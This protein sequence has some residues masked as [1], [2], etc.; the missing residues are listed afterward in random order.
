MIELGKLGRDK[1]TGFE[2]I[3]TCHAKYLYGC[4]RYCLTPTSRD[5]DGKMLDG[6]FLDEGRIE[7]LGEGIKPQEVQTEKKGGDK[8]PSSRKDNPA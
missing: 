6:E 3:V 5:K 8:N 4:D 1:I 2:G 7:V